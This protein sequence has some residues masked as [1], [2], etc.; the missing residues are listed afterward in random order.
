MYHVLSSVRSL[1]NSGPGRNIMG[2]RLWSHLCVSSLT[3]RASSFLGQRREAGR[4]GC[5]WPTWAV[6]QD[7]AGMG[8]GQ[9]CGHFQLIWIHILSHH[10]KLKQKNKTN[11]KP[12][13]VQGVWGGWGWSAF[14]WGQ[15][16][17][18]S[19]QQALLPPGAPVLHASLL[20]LTAAEPTLF[21]DTTS[22][23]MPSSPLPA[24]LSLPSPVLD[25]N[26]F[27]AAQHCTVRP[28]LIF[29][30]KLNIIY[31]SLGLFLVSRTCFSENLSFYR[32]L[33]L[34]CDGERT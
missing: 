18:N 32:F 1:W 12:R 20:S 2:V 13:Q 4:R 15:N 5:S 17:Q 19:L 22:Y 16:L 8:W 33:I 26:A 24:S 29:L 25:P 6:L 9:P 11:Q 3:V 28:V 10:R 23:K 31:R 7:V 21:G 27:L 14:C 30:L 34:L